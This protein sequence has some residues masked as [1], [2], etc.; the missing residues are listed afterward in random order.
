MKFTT[1]II[2]YKSL[3]K[4]DECIKT[5]GEKKE[6]LVIENSKDI[7]IKNE[8]EKKYKN[9]S[10]F[11]NNE[12]LGYSA[13]SNIG[14]R[15]I[16]NDYVLLINTDIVIHEQ[17]ISEIEKEI[18][19]L[20]GKFTLASPLS[21]DLIDFNKN[22]KLDSFFEKDIAYFDLNKKFTKVDLVKGCSLLINLKKFENR[23][24]FDDNFFFF[25][26]EI[27]LCRK[28]KEKNQDIFVFNNIKIEHKSAQG[29]NENLNENYQNFRNWNYFWGRFYYFKK[30]YGY[31]FSLFKHLSKLL[32][33]SF[34]ILRYFFIS[35]TLYNKNKYRFLGLFSSM[36][37]KKSKLSVKILEKE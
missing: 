7:Q 30:H 27:D 37:G 36:I 5:I 20:E 22:N 17:Q 34:N 35:K 24:V 28:V 4:L 26:E 25:F 6:I 1:L 16:K 18:D 9:C 12:N 15:N 14:F 11:L 33:F 13:A 3:N 2:S 23:K 8:I 29:I 21:D 19:A 31:T 10:V 32:R